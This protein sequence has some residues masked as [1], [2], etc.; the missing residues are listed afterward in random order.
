MVMMVEVKVKGK[1]LKKKMMVKR[2]LMKL[3]KKTIEV[4]QAATFFL[5]IQ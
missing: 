2:D 4:N 5:S 1:R 3:R